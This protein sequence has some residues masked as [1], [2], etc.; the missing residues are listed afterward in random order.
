MRAN[1]TEFLISVATVIIWLI[2]RGGTACTCSHTRDRTTRT[3]IPIAAEPG[4]RHTSAAAAAATGARIR[5]LIFS[6]VGA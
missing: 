6:G 1:L 2:G 5:G 4:T 3:V